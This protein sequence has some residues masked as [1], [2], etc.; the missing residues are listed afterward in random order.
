MVG[1]VVLVSP[2]DQLDRRCAYYYETNVYSPR[3]V[4]LELSREAKHP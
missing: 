1:T 4:N 2:L 3:P